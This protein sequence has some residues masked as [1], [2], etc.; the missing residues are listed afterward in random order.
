MGHIDHQIGADL[1]GDGAET[2][3][4]HH[5]R[6][7]RKPGDNHLRLV[8]QGQRFHLVVVHLAGSAVQAI[9]H[10]VIHLAGKIDTGAVGEMAAVRQAHTEHSIAGEAEGLVDRRVRLGAGMRLHVGIGRAEQGLG[11][12]NGQG[13]GLVDV[14][15]A[16][17]IALAG[18][19]LGVFIGQRGSLGRQ[20]ARAGVVF[21]GNQLDM[22]L[23]ATLLFRDGREYLVVESLDAHVF[24]EHGV[25]L[26]GWRGFWA[27]PELKGAHSTPKIP[28]R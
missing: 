21:R 5:P 25:P 4:V 26:A 20:H 12:L 6:I 10:R 16:A 11:P 18:V 28:P 1:I 19:A 7:G 17:V 14:F 8:L 9:L 23:L 3:P 27:H 22:L 24:V 2:G 15:T 13:L